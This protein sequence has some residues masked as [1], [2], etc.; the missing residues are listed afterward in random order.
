MFAIVETGG[1]QYKVS[2]GTVLRVEKLDAAVGDEVVFDRVLAVDMDGDFKVGK[3]YLPGVQ[4]KAK[5]LDQGK[6]KKI[7]VFKYK[8]KKNYRRRKG[9]RQLFTEVIVEEISLGTQ[10]ETAAAE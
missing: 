9:H 8:P 5:V 3:P 2:K 6:S 7:L 4:V 1:K 10:E